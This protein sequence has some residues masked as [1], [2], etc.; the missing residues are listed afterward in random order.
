MS[1]NTQREA[2]N[3]RVG[4]LERHFTLGELARAWHVS[5]RTL[6]AWF[7]NEPG[8]IR[9]G[10]G[11]LKRGRKQLHQSVRVPESVAQRVR[12]AHMSK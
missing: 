12:R 1:E 4:V 2:Q 3:E 8:V 10:G 5:R 7:D 11:K 6:V 9:W